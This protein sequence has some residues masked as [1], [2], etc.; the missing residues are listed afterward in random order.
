M[1][2]QANRA[3]GICPQR[4]VLFNH[5]TV[6]EHVKFW[7]QIKG[8]REDAAAIESLIEACDLTMKTHSRAGTL[9]GGQKRKLQL[10][11]MF[12]G[13]STVCLMDEVTSGLVSNFPCS[14]PPA[15]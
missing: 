7:S 10:A 5:L 13:G 15:P 6:Y 11:C 9:S 4:N 1:L 12:V 3:T 2:W 8:G 14:P